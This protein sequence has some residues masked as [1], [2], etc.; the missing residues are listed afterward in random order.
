MIFH[1]F[2]IRLGENRSAIIV[3]ELRERNECTGP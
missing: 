2:Y 3:T 1:D